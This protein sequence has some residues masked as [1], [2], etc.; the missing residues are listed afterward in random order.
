MK[1]IYTLLLAGI[2][3]LP[4]VVSADM[5]TT[6]PEVRH[7]SGSMTPRAFIIASGL[8]VPDELLARLWAIPSAREII[9]NIWRI[10]TFGN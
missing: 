1:T 10:K 5:G 2:L 3:V 6:T 8:Y 4:F 7:S 9:M